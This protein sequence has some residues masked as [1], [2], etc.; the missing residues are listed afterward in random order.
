MATT[1]KTA[2]IFTDADLDRAA[3]VVRDASDAEETVTDKTTLALATTA[4]VRDLWSP[5]IA[6]ELAEA[7]FDFIYTP[8]T[9]E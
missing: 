8:A 4:L 6:A 3:K 5:A 2:K 7:H 1:A 9:A